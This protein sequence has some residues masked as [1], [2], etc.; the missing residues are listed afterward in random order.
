MIKEYVQYWDKNKNWLEKYFKTH[1]QSDYSDYLDLVK[2]LFEIVINPEEMPMRAFD[3]NKIHVIDDGDYQGTQIFIIP[4]DT[5]QPN[6]SE[7]VYTN[8]YYGF[9]SGCDTLMA[10]QSCGLP[11]EEQIKDYMVLCLHLLQSCAYMVDGEEENNRR[12]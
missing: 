5:C 4:S 1:D 10:M 8:T 6:V 2:L 11:D 9:C 12:S 7:Y 3:I